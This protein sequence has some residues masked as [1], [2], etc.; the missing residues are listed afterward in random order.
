MGNFNLGA[1]VCLS[2]DHDVRYAVLPVRA[3]IYRAAYM[4]VG[5]NVM[6]SAAYSVQDRAKSAYDRVGTHIRG[7]IQEA[8][9]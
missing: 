6:A 1:R 9:H 5:F 8:R 4:G 3:V 7:A 2:V